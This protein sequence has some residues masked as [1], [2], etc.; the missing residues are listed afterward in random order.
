M[1][2][3]HG[4]RFVTTFKMTH[5]KLGNK[6]WFV[7]REKSN[8]LYLCCA[9]ATWPHEL[10]TCF[11]RPMMAAFLLHVPIFSTWLPFQFLKMGQKCK[12]PAAPLF[13]PH[14]ICHGGNQ[15]QGGAPIPRWETYHCAQGSHHPIPGPHIHQA[16]ANQPPYSPIVQFVRG[17]KVPKN[18][19]LSCS[20]TLKKL[21]QARNDKYKGQG[22]Q[23]E[24]QEKHFLMT[25]NQLLAPKGSAH[26]FWRPPRPLKEGFWEA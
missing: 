14:L 17:G 16:E 15:P 10:G 11:S 9:K 4:C 3:I 18:S 25:K 20:S 22:P 12:P 2:P 24:G 7:Y 19:S 13:V 8:W 21:I 6:K 5:T 26:F 23:E 1:W